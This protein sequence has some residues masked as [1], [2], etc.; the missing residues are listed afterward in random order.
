MNIKIAICEKLIV[1]NRYKNPSKDSLNISEIILNAATTKPENKVTI[2]A[3]GVTLFHVIP[4]KNT[5]ATG[6]AI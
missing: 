2:A 3:S 4:S 6:G 5:A 1:A